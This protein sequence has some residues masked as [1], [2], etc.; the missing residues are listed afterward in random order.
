MDG[1]RRMGNVGLERKKRVRNKAQ[2]RYEHVTTRY[3]RTKGYSVS[4]IRNRG[5][6]AKHVK[7][8]GGGVQ[9]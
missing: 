9:E 5:K 4:R 8:C 3:Q 7:E 1:L 6:D 2:R